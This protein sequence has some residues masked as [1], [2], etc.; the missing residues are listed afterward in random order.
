MLRVLTEPLKTLP[1]MSKNTHFCVI[2]VIKAFC[3]I[4]TSMLLKELFAVAALIV[5]NNNK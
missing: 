1:A 4:S 5:K 3:S 2:K